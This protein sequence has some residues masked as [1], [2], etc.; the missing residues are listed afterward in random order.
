[1]LIYVSVEMDTRGVVSRVDYGA[2]EFIY[3]I[4]IGL[5]LRSPYRQ[6]FSNTHCMDLAPPRVQISDLNMTNMS[7]TF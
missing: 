2:P 3:N 6:G 4:L 1:M 5:K 7:G